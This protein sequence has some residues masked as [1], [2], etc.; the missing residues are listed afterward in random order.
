MLG[1]ARLGLIV[2]TCRPYLTNGV[3]VVWAGWCRLMA[4]ADHVKVVSAERVA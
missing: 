3:N 2:D 1:L 4:W